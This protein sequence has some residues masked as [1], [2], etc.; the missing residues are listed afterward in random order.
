VHGFQSSSE[1]CLIF[2]LAQRDWAD[3]MVEWP[4][5][6]VQVLSHQ[7]VNQTL[8]I[9]ERKA[10]AAAVRLGGDDLGAVSGSGFS[11]RGGRRLFSELAADS[12][13]YRHVEDYYNDFKREPL[14]PHQYSREGP[15]LAAGDVD[16]DGKVDFFVGG[17]RG[18]AGVVY[19]NEGGG[20]FVPL[21]INVLA[22]QTETEQV[23]A[24]LADIDHDG[25]LDLYVVSGGNED[26]FEDHIYWNDGHGNFAERAGALPVTVSSGKA[27]VT[28]DLDK[29]G[30]PDIFR[31]GQ[32]STGAWPTAPVSYLFHNEHGVLKDVTPEF[33]RHI[34]MVSTAFAADVNGDGITDLVIAG[35]FMPVT[36][37]YGLGKAPYFSV[38]NRLVIPHS[39]GWWNCLRV[40]DIDGDGDLDIIAGNEGLNCQ[41][42]PG[43]GQPLTVDA[44]DADNN[45]S[46]DAILS[47]Y[48]QGKSYPVAT[49]DEL[50]DE[51]PSM[52]S[53]FPNY[54]AYAD[55]TVSNIFSPELLSKALHLEAE[56]FRSGV[57]VNEKGAFRFVPFRVAAQ[58]FPVRDVL[59]TDVGGRTDLLLTGN[60]YAVRAQWGREDAGKGLVLSLRKDGSFD[61]IQN[62]G[63]E[64]DRDARGMVRIDDYILVANN[65]DILQIFHIN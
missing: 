54:T 35:E 34:G 10:P 59:V 21:K 3:V 27:V 41:Y 4:D 46:L 13:R 12:L 18:Q 63:L 39:S 29:D 17:A 7:K 55:A 15:A 36:I 37:L 44:A 40:A 23:S 49:R 8:L 28:L 62:S 19:H 43:V 25:D 32:V 16:G 5:G 30:F 9:D 57:F 20:H 22:T 42:K 1:P 47:C 53:R 6:K 31:G 58:A 24:L 52:K 50:I 60:N 56:E 11:D 26:H 65:N 38:E 64:T 14:L 45:G 61:V 48:I 2:G 33:L 51:V